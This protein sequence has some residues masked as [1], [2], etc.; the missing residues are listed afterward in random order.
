[1]CIKFPVTDRSFRSVLAVLASRRSKE[2]L[3]YIRLGMELTV[4]HICWLWPP[5]ESE[6]SARTGGMRGGSGGGGP[7]VSQSVILR[8][9]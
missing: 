4:L 2:S 8:E 1:M 9:S 5:A 6:I 7:S 3:H